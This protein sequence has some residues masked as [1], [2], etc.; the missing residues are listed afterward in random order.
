ML[1][2][3]V[4]ETNA[5]IRDLDKVVDMNPDNILIYFNRGI[6]ENGD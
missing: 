6:V 1:H 2:A 4:G 5:A 3:E